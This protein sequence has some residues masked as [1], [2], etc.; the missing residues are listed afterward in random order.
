MADFEQSFHD[1]AKDGGVGEAVDLADLG[2]GRAIDIG[3]QG[4]DRD[5]VVEGLTDPGQ[6]VGQTGTGYD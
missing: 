5:A 6:S 1:R 3:D 4:D 2:V